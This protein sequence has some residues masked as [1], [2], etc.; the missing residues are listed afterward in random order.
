MNVIEKQKLHLIETAYKTSPIFF[1]MFFDK[2]YRRERYDTIVDKIDK[3]QNV[4][5][6]RNL[7]ISNY[8]TFPAA[9][10]RNLYIFK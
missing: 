5:E 8:H 3:Y 1:K 2:M 7:I 6:F 10:T 4:N 9:P